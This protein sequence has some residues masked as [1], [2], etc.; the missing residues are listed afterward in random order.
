MKTDKFNQLL[1]F[2]RRLEAAKIAYQLRHSRY[3][4]LMVEI[5]VPGER[6]EVEFLEDDEIEV[7]RFRSNGH[8]DDEAA[9]AEL[10][11]KFSDEEV[12]AS[13]DAA[14]RP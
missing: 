2:L 7:E 10:F 8:I 11:A 14:S 5:N 12:P 1:G 6:W 9:L 4:A 13:H 3:D